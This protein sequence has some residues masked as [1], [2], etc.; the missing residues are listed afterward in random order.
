M[1]EI[2]EN[3]HKCR[4]NTQGSEE[5]WELWVVCK[6]LE[7]LLYVKQTLKEI[8]PIHKVLNFDKTIPN[9]YELTP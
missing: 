1:Q 9:P 2:V 4:S 7:S 6:F 8:S 3:C 5:S